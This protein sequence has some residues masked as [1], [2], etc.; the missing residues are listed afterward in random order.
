MIS[1]FRRVLNVRYTHIIILNYALEHVHCKYVNN[2]SMIFVLRRQYFEANKY[3]KLL[4]V[5]VVF[6]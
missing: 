3:F 1:P 5:Y 4:I 6:Q 2:V